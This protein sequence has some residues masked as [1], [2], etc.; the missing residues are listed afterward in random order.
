VPPAARTD[1]T[2]DRAA[3]I[4]A[5]PEAA[6]SPRDQGGAALEVPPAARAGRV[7]ARAAV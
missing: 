1:K 3:G 7:A 5:A 2:A 6:G 4:A